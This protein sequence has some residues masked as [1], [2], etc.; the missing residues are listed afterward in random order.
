MPNPYHIKVDGLRKMLNVALHT[1]PSSQTS[2]FHAEYV[3][4]GAS[5]IEVLSCMVSRLME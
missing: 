3:Y 1:Q 2:I 5:H 4:S